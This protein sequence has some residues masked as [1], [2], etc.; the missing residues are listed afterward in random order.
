MVSYTF[1]MLITHSSVI[2]NHLFEDGVLGD[3]ETDMFIST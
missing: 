3:E 1:I 2:Y